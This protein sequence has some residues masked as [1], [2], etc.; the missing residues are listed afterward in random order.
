MRWKADSRIKGVDTRFLPAFVVDV[1]LERAFFVSF[2]EMLNFH[3]FCFVEQGAV[4]TENTLVF[5][6]EG[7]DCSGRHL[8]K[9]KIKRE[10]GCL[11]GCQ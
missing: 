11:G 2:N 6:V 9:L 4:K 10:W 7:F 8:G 3:Y 1:V 5:F